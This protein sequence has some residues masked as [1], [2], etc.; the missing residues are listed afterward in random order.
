MKL[1]SDFDVN[2]TFRGMFGHKV[3]NATNMVFDNPTYFPTRNIL[4]SA[5]ERTE[6]SGPSAFSDYFLERGDFVRLENITI[7][8]SLN[9]LNFKNISTARVFVNANNLMTLTGY[10][11]I[12]P[13]TIGIDIFNVYP[14]STSVTLG[15]SMTF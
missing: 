8:Y 13:G 6:L 3:L 5:P 14:K 15:F 2:F 7:G 1:F 10:S 4:N 12:D 11:G 9:K